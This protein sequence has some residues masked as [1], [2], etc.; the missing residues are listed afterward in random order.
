MQ[1]AWLGANDASGS[2][3]SLGSPPLS[4]PPLPSLPAF[5]EAKGLEDRN[6]RCFPLHSMVPREEQDVASSRVGPTGTS[7]PGSRREGPPS[8]CC[9]WVFIVR[10]RVK[11]QQTTGGKQTNQETHCERLRL[12]LWVFC[13]EGKT[14][15]NQRHTLEK[16]TD[17]FKSWIHRTPVAR[18]RCSIL[19]V[20]T[21]ET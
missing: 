21:K 1:L 2:A 14:P 4:A 20:R 10:G 9:C 5:Q 3:F 8:C 12:C 11:K 6:F 19:V 18:S 15:A 17:G 7:G 13:T 16:P